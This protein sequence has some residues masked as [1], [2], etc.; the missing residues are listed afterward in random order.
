MPQHILHYLHISHFSKRSVFGG[1]LLCASW[2][3]KCTRG[4]SSGWRCRLVSA[5]CRKA[6]SVAFVVSICQYDMQHMSIFYMHS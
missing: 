2:F 6:S 4:V 3:S 5:A 1:F